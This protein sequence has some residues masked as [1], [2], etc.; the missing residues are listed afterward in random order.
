VLAETPRGVVLNKMDTLTPEEGEARARE[1]VAAL[2]WQGPVYR[3]SAETG[4]HTEQLCRDIM[5]ALEQMDEEA[6]FAAPQ[7][8]DEAH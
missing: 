7:M 4:L 1:I 2:G 5:Q 8:P 3:I 6:D